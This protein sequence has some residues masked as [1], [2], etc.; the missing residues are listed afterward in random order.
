MKDVVDRWTR[1]GG[2]S[3]ERANVLNEGELAKVLLP[4]RAYEIRIESD[5]RK[6]AA[7]PSVYREF[8]AND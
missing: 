4:M 5:D 1:A 3:C 8:V 6:H 2:Y 7:D